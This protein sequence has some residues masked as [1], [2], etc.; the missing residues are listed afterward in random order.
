V[1]AQQALYLRVVRQ[2]MAEEA[3]RK[4]RARRPPSLGSSPALFSRREHMSMH[5][6]AGG[7]HWTCAVVRGGEREIMVDLVSRSQV[8]G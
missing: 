4:T 2:R 6:G 8:Q 3:Y 1:A 5:D 7:G